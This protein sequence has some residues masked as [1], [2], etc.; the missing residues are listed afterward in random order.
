MPAA[1]FGLARGSPGGEVVLDIRG[2]F[3]GVNHPVN[4]PAGSLPAIPGAGGG[5]SF[6]GFTA[7]NIDVKS[8]TGFWAASCRGVTAGVSDGTSPRNG[9][10]KKLVNSPSFGPSLG[11]GAVT[12]EGK[13]LAAK[14]GL[15]EFAG[16]P[17][18]GSA[19]G[20]AGVR[21]DSGAHGGAECRPD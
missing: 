12:G 9:P 17:P 7:P 1:G 8:P 14:S 4:D 5:S 11:G 19:F 3:S 15:N 13:F 6:C 10:W 21:A 18:L 2:E 20:G 16:L